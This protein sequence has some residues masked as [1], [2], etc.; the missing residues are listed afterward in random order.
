M[1]VNFTHKVS[2]EPKWSNM[3]ASNALSALLLRCLKNPI[4]AKCYTVNEPEVKPATSYQLQSKSNQLQTV[5]P[6]IPEVA[7]I[8]E[9]LL[10]AF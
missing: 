5:R 10:V 1:R 2:R 7:S 4:P 9:E 3:P 8:E 6:C